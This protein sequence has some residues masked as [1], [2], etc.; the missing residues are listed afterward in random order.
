VL[1]GASQGRLRILDDLPVQAQVQ[2]LVGQ[3]GHDVS[4]EAPVT[5]S[6]G[7]PQR[8]EEI[9]LRHP[10]AADIAGLGEDCG[11]RVLRVVRKARGR[12]APAPIADAAAWL[13]ACGVESLRL[14][15]RP[16]LPLVVAGGCQPG[17]SAHQ[18]KRDI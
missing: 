12:R 9:P 15:S 5:G 18:M 3:Q 11:N 16:A 2:G 6:L 1:P 4:A 13:I 14:W 10:C 17:R 7:H 8:V